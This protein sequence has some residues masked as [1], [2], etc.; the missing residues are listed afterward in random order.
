MSSSELHCPALKRGAANPC[1]FCHLPSGDGHCAERAD[2]QRRR[3]E[4]LCPGCDTWNTIYEHPEAI[5]VLRCI[6]CRREF[7]ARN[8][9]YRKG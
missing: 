6:G 4:C 7:V 1:R 5:N 2:I 3:W 9:A 8:A